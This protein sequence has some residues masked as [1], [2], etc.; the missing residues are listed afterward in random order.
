VDDAAA[1]RRSVEEERAWREAL[2]LGDET[3]LSP[4]ARRAFKGLR[5]FPI[6]ARWR[7]R[8]VKLRRHATPIRD[9]LGATGADAVRMLEVG[10]FELDVAGHHA[11]LFA[12][13]PAPGEADEDYLLVP[14]RDAT[15]GKETYGGG[16]YVDVEPRPDDVYELDLNRCYH[17][18]CAHDDGWAC[19]LPPPENRLGFR[20]DAGERL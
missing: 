13:A 6:D 15:S 17:P 1:W 16:R 4:D 18:Y 7:A 5:W 11:R 10:V 8:G 3:P 12:Y 19:V 20:V 9:R 14:F 2:Y